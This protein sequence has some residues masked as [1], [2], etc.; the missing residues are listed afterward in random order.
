[1][2]PANNNA[3]GRAVRRLQRIAQPWTPLAGIRPP[4]G[5]QKGGNFLRE[6]VFGANDGLVSNVA[7][8]AGVAGGTNDPNVILLGGV[9]GM[10]AGAISMALGAYVSTKSEH[11]FREAEEARER[12]EVDNMRDQELAE[13]RHIFRLKGITGPLLDEVVDVVSRDH[14]QW[15]KLMMTEELGFADQSPRPKV[16]AMV[17]GLAF[18]VGAVFPVVPYFVAEGN[19][20]F[21]TSLSL[22]AAAL[23]GVGALRATMTTGSMFRKGIEM[24]VLG[25][26][27]VA[28]A[29]LIG[30]AV[31]VNV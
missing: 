12:W 23:F 10:V 2:P 31:G 9:A 25:G 14:E 3:F 28:I 5:H 6:L 4:E 24:V 18:S 27:A 26:A 7:L 8:V 1:V 13:T 22:T 21:I 11:E 19:V 17:M 16:S 15:I 30:R 29:N 20:A